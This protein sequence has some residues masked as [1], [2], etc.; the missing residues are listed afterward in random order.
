MDG[1]YLSD[2]GGVVLAASGGK[3]TIIAGH[4]VNGEELL[5][6]MLALTLLSGGPSPR[7]P[8]TASSRNS[9]RLPMPLAVSLPLRQPM[10]SLSRVIYL[11][12]VNYIRFKP[13]M[14]KVCIILPCPKASSLQCSA[15]MSPPPTHVAFDERFVES[16]LLDRSNIQH[17]AFAAGRELLLSYSHIPLENIPA[18]VADIVSLNQSVVFGLSTRDPS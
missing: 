7:G 8:A 13:Q 6:T 4:N 2:V 12:T 17:P 15:T 18:H 16:L 11:K 5:L 14:D 10:R 3:P 1:G 9:G